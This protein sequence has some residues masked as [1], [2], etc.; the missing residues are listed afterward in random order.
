[1]VYRTR[2]SNKYGAKKTTYNGY[3]YDSKFEASVAQELELEKRAGNIKDFDRQYRV[4]MYAYS[5]CLTR[6]MKKSHKVDF[7]VHNNDGT[8]TLLEA[9][10]L[11]TQ[12][13]KDR[14][15]WLDNFWLPLHPDH[16]YVVEYQRQR[17]WRPKG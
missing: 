17:T 9:K 7:R 10:G 15:K 4:D 13:W 8:F 6:K 11:P 14:V 1:L 3:K 16:D 2:K 12:D 5:Q